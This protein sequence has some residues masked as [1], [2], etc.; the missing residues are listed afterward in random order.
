EQYLIYFCNFTFLNE[1]LA[2]DPRIGMFLPFRATVVKKDDSVLVMTVNP[3]YL[4]SLFNNNELKQ[5]CEYMSE[6]Y[7]AILEESTL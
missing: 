4:C 6:K 5:K 7:E 3:D 2:V 1:A